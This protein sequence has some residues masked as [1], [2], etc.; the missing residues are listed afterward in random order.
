MISRLYDDDV[1]NKMPMIF[2][3]LTTA[4]STDPGVFAKICC[5]G[6]KPAPTF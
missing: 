2:P 5:K 3:L 1:H 6:L 4:W